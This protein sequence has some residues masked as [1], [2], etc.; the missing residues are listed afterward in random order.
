[1]IPVADYITRKERKLINPK[2]VWGVYDTRYSDQQGICE[3][4]MTEW[5]IPLTNLIGVDGQ[6][7][8]RATAWA[9]VGSVVAAALPDDCEAI[10]CSPSMDKAI[11]I[12]SSEGD[13]GR[14]SYGSFLGFIRV[15]EKMLAVATGTADLEYDPVEPGYADIIF[16][17]QSS[18]YST[19]RYVPYNANGPSGALT[20]TLDIRKYYSSRDNYGEEYTGDALVVSWGSKAPSTE[21]FGSS[22]REESQFFGANNPVFA[23]ATANKPDGFTLGGLSFYDW[24][25]HGKPEVNSVPNVTLDYIIWPETLTQSIT[26][27][28]W[29]LGETIGGDPWDVL[30]FWRLGWADSRGDSAMTGIPA[31]TAADATALAQR[32]KATRFSLTERQGLSSVIGINPIQ[33]IYSYWLGEAY[34]CAFDRLLIDLGFS[35]QKIKLGYWDP[36]TNISLDGSYTAETPYLRF[37]SYSNMLN[38]Y[39]DPYVNPYPEKE[40]SVYIY[41]LTGGTWTLER[42]FDSNPKAEARFASRVALDGDTL[43]VLG[44]FNKL[45]KIYVKTAEGWTLQQT[46]PNLNGVAKSLTLEGDVL[47]FSGDQATVRIFNRTGATWVEAPSIT[48]SGTGSPRYITL[49][50]DTLA[51]ATVSS[52]IEVYFRSTGAWTLQ[53]ELSSVD[54]KYIALSGDTLV[55]SHGRSNDL[56][57]EV[58]F[59]FT[60]TGTLWNS[61]QTIAPPYTPTV[62]TAFGEAIAIDGDTIVIGEPNFRW[63]A[64][65]SSLVNKARGKA[66]VYTRTGGLWSLQEE[67][68]P[69]NPLA[70]GPAS[71]NTSFGSQVAIENDRIVVNDSDVLLPGGAPNILQSLA[72][73]LETFTRSG[74]T[75]NREEKLGQPLATILEKNKLGEGGV[76]ISNNVIV[77]AAPA[78]QIT[79]SYVRTDWT[80]SSIPAA[81]GFSRYDSAN[82]DY[83]YNGSAP[84]RVEAINGNS[85]PFPVDNFFYDGLNRNSGRSSDRP[86]PTYFEEGHPDQVYSVRNGAVGFSTPSYNNCQG[87]WFIKAGGTAWR[88]SYL[89][90]YADLSSNSANPFFVNL[91]R[92]HQAATASLMAGVDIFSQ[93]ELIGDGLAQ[94]F[95]RQAVAAPFTGPPNNVNNNAFYCDNDLRVFLKNSSGQVWRIPTTSAPTA[96]Q[97]AAVASFPTN[98]LPYGGD[99]VTQV[100]RHTRSKRVSKAPAEWSFTTHIQPYNYNSLENGVDSVLWELLLN[101]TSTVDDSAVEQTSEHL[102]TTPT[103]NEVLEGFELLYLYPNSEG[104]RVS[105]CHVASASISIDLKTVAS[106]EWSGL[107]TSLDTYEDSTDLYNS[108]ALQ[109]YQGLV[110]SNYIVNKLS[111][112]EFLALGNPVVSSNIVISRDLQP[113]SFE[114]MN[115]ESKPVGF[116]SSTLRVQGSLQMYIDGENRQNVMGALRY[117]LEQENSGTPDIIINIGGVTP[118]TSRLQVHVGQ[119]MLSA[120]ELALEGLGIVNI[121]FEAYPYIQDFT[122]P[123][124]VKSPVTISYKSNSVP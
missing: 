77:A 58:V 102:K 122:S 53:A 57:E 107:G 95:A 85:L 87:S 14:Y 54:A 12:E 119:S 26:P 83:K 3:A 11:W 98:T 110:Q 36:G 116:S 86:T 93:E 66:Y 34:W 103:S 37:G 88:G 1:M 47:A 74:T 82:F 84:N 7:R 17:A 22:Y 97:Q 96:T 64:I 50:N 10:F 106:T 79:N 20:E 40:G 39:R 16:K 51:V 68:D 5:D 113:T 48:I 60:R 43:A 24:K 9:T 38:R 89:E 112:V 8:T 76:Y 109:N 72:G 81:T 44:N 45:I 114:L 31:F 69:A 90:P 35:E 15:F 100:N 123:G 49:S 46:I 56:A 115:I 2:K 62:T 28:D 41:T 117:L 71:S 99:S 78:T 80:Y 42:L 108:T 4:Y 21:Y 13:A 27:I 18:F 91:L 121:N 32:S 55:A 94:P 120:P 52:T 33:S 70:T 92:G 29:T 104:F 30:P 65:T 111:T 25:G 19:L 6:R 59:V 61:G 73:Q 23:S 101:G 124:T 105:G 75:W 63:E 118:N 67:L